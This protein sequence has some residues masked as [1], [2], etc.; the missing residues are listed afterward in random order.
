MPILIRND[1]YMECLWRIKYFFRWFHNYKIVK[2]KVNESAN[3]SEWI[4][5]SFVSLK[6]KKTKRISLYLETELREKED[7]LSIIKYEPYKRNKAVLSLLWDLDTR[8]HE[9]TLLKIKH[10]RIREKYGKG[11]IPHEVKTGTGPILLTCSLPYVRDWVND[12][13]FK[14]EPNA[15]L[16]YM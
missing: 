1:H 2:E 8:P 12:H 15:S 5:P 4:A 6:K 7:L 16:I 11:E 10:I 3:T 13:P 9:V 14:N